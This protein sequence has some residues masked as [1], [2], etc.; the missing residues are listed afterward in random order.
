VPI[1]ADQTLYGFDSFFTTTNDIFRSAS[2][3]CDMFLYPSRDAL[4]TLYAGPL[5]D[6]ANANITKFWNGNTAGGSYSTST[7]TPTNAS[8]PTHYLT[9]DNSREKPYADIYPR[10]TTKSNTFTV[11][12]YV[13][14]L[15]KVIGSSPT[16]W[17]EATDKVTG[18]Y[19]GST[20]FERYVNPNDTTLPDFAALAIAGTPKA[21]DSFY[22]FRVVNERQF[23]P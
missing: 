22:K 2:Q 20:T 7:T 4:M 23:A 11:H 17:N 3:I 19:R 13:Q 15:Q 9:G 6:A 10:L 16:L 8:W 18:E 1:N 12:Y 5:W 21:L 14:T